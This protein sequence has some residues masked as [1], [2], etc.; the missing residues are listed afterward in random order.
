MMSRTGA[1]LTKESP[2]SPCTA[3]ATKPANCWGIG[4][5][6]P[7]SAVTVAMVSGVAW[8]PSSLYHR[9]ARYQANY[10][11]GA[12]QDRDEHPGAMEQPASQVDPHTPS[13]APSRA[14]W[15]LDR[16]P[17]ALLLLFQLQARL[18]LQRISR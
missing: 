6:K 15:V 16:N 1:R 8:I 13:N 5:S 14:G 11:E 2:R 4:L 12:D 10:E 18:D 7:S 17:P 3:L 9:I